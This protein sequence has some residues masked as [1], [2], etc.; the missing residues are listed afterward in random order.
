MAKTSLFYAE[1]NRPLTANARPGEGIHHPRFGE[2]LKAR[3]EPLGVACS[4]RHNDDYRDQDQPEE[5]MYRDLV[6]FLAG[7]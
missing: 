2:A 4:L 7:Q 6:G 5:A 1:P 3:L